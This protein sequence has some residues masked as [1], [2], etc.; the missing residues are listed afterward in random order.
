MFK[1]TSLEQKVVCL[2]CIIVY[3][4]I[5]KN[6]LIPG[7]LMSD[8]STSIVRNIQKK[9]VSK[10]ADLRAVIESLHALVRVARRVRRESW[11]NEKS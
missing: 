10:K 9:T 3:G 2:V 8:E 5:K 6:E 1:V 11:R 4:A 7:F